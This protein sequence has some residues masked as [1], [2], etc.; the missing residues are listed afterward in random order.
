MFWRPITLKKHDLEK[1]DPD[2]YNDDVQERKRTKIPIST[3]N[4][5][6]QTCFSVDS[7]RDHFLRR[8]VERRQNGLFS[9]IDKNSFLFPSSVCYNYLTATVFYH[10][11]VPWPKVSQFPGEGRENCMIYK[12]STKKAGQTISNFHL[13]QDVWPVLE[14]GLEGCPKVPIKLFCNRW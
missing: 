10:K 11:N 3:L 8:W 7:R 1:T 4:L 6:I 5:K 14:N 13:E 9:K 12:L 2:K